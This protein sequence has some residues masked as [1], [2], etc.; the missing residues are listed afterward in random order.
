M[1]AKV[2]DN[3]RSMEICCAFPLHKHTYIH[4]SI[5]FDRNKLTSRLFTKHSMLNHKMTSTIL[6]YNK[7]KFSLFYL[8]LSAR[9]AHSVSVRS[10][11]ISALP[12]GANEKKGEAIEIEPKE[13]T[14]VQG[15]NM[16]KDSISRSYFHRFNTPRDMLM[17][18]ETERTISRAE[19]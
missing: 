12:F 19:L 5:R 16:P 7:C 3:V 8:F 17:C 11:L 4:N 14:N 18:K 6:T 15:S 1:N 2:T 10:L 13:K 9:P